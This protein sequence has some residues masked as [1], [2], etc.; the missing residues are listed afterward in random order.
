[1]VIIIIDDEHKAREALKAY[2]NLL[3][4]KN[5][6]EIILCASVKE[7]VAAIEKYIPDL[8]FLDIEM[9]EANGFEL[10]Q[11]VNKESFEVVFVTAYS[12]FMEKSVNE[13]G[14]F[15]YLYK[16]VAR[17]KLLKIFERFNEKTPDK[18]YLKFVNKDSKKRMMVELD[19]ILFCK[20]DNN[21]AEIYLKD[22]SKCELTQALGSL[23]DKLPKQFVR[24]H[25]SFIVN[26]NHV[27]SFENKSNKLYLK[28]GLS[29]EK[30]I[31]PVTKKHKH[32]IKERFL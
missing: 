28:S 11:Q 10:F 4:P 17:E 20:A 31:I 32:L 6:F 3:L 24:T 9:P 21:Y 8:V 18:K 25:R 23:E 19:N 27:E 7:G 30:Q 16:P 13:I 29:E 15:G 22:G 5:N 2:I 12:E 1:M 26:L 14:C